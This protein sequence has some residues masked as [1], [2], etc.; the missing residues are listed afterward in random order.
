[1]LLNQYVDVIFAKIHRFSPRAVFLTL[2][3]LFCVLVVTNGVS[4]F[5]EH[6]QELS[7]NPFID[8]VNTVD[9][10]Q[11]SV[12][13][14]LIAYYTQMNSKTSF[15]V[16]CL[17]IYV[18]SCL[19]FAKLTLNRFGVAPALIFTSVLITSPLTTT[20]LSWLGTVD[21]MTFA[22]TMPFI[23]THSKLLILILS[24]LGPMNHIV[25]II[26]T[27][28]ILVLRRISRSKIGIDHLLI[29]TIG[30]IAGFWLLKLFLA[31]NQFHISESRLDVII[32]NLEF[33]IGMNTTPSHH[34]SFLSL[35]SIHWLVIIIS[36]LMFYR[37]DRVYYSS[38][39][40]I[41]IL[42][43][44]ITFFTADTT[45]V[46]LLLSWGVL[47]ECMFHSYRLAL[48]QEDK[49]FQKQYLA[50]LAIIGLM[51]FL[52]PRYYSFTGSIHHPPYFQF[53]VDVVNSRVSLTWIAAALFIVSIG[54]LSFLKVKMRFVWYYSISYF[55]FTAVISFFLSFHA[56]SY[57]RSVA[58]RLPSEVGRYKDGMIE[59]VE[60]K[61]G[62][63]SFGPY[64][65]LKSGDYI[66]TFE[67]ISKSPQET[68]VGYVDVTTDRGRDVIVKKGVYG[69]EGVSSRIE[70]LF[71]LQE[72][73]RDVEVRFWYEGTGSVSLH[74]LEIRQQ[75]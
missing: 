59:S 3:F 57:F 14:P 4:P 26:A 32:R 8:G 39:I 51:S 6:Y 12:L 31:S 19:M 64:I 5:P 15:Y 46:F 48:S 67:Y 47:V 75:K 17:L 38:L 33:W 34:T 74:T 16:L 52:V 9:Y 69:T 30:Y 25:F 68:I 37:I 13:L 27:I 49:D 55:L 61:P 54:V 42:N 41:L 22:L 1:M 40:V 36:M 72:D 20:T 65:N 45:R 7:Q 63:L 50:S 62:F 24:I 71:S 23:F 18:I 70:V 44:G 73:E 11:E 35:F 66:A 28:E 60:G 53:A 43:L 56:P 29:A 21:S 58:A 2:I 10:W